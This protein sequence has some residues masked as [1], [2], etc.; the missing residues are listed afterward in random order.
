MDADRY[1]SL[2]L[3]HKDRVH[4]YAAWMLGDLEEARDVTQEALVRLWKNRAKVIPETSRAWL[5]RTTYRL[6]IDR[7][8]RRKVRGEVGGE[9][10]LDPVPDTAAGPERLAGSSMLGRAISDAL[11]K[12]GEADRTVV[13]LREV[14][15]MAYDEIS[16]VTNMPLGTIKAKLHR[17]RDRLRRELTAAGVR[18]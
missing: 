11:G 8:R 2:V 18:P 17:A 14:Q 3:E 15:G 10:I 4:S 7:M 12:L 13:L 1:R 5:L 9:G 16:R 6:C